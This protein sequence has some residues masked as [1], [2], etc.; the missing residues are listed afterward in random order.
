MPQVGVTRTLPNA[1]GT[2]QAPVASPQTPGL[3][4]GPQNKITPPPAV[5]PP[6]YTPPQ[7]YTPPPTT[8][9]TN[10]YINP[11]TGSYY[12]PQ[13]YA[14]VVMQK[15]PVSKGSGDV[16]QYAGDALTNPNQT[17]EQLNRS[18]Y[19][20]NNARND[21]AVGQTDPYDITQGGKIVYSPQERAAIEKAYAGIY[22]PALSDVF[23]KLDTK[24]K[25]E[26]SDLEQKNKLELMAKQHE[27]NLAEQ[28]DKAAL[29]GAGGI[30]GYDGEFAGTIDLVANMESSVFGKKN[31]KQQLANLLANKDYTTA[32]SQIAN[33]V[34]NGLV[35]ESKQKFV[36][37][38]TDYNVMEGMKEA[39]KAYAQ[40]G[41][42]MGLLKG[43]EEEI[44]RKLGIDSGKAS[45][46]AVQLW[47]EFQV[48][49]NNMTGAAF[50]AAES[51]D[52]ASVNPSLG[53]S[54]NLNLAVIEGA[55]NQ[56]KNRITSTI[57]ERV[58]SAQKILKLAEGDTSSD[59]GADTPSGDPE[60]DAYLKAIK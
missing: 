44:K 28:R 49:R 17:K 11:A 39:I 1:G 55:Q 9:T 30:T 47:R 46:L 58:P 16:T 52:Y 29:D 34:E 12:T 48:Y 21:I 37:A 22:D 20:L 35:G 2:Y 50:G 15:L 19:S 27:Y 10:K 23:T 4:I 31:V 24:A 14:N 54:L 25:Q 6:I 42:D 60:Y 8:Q 32:Y 36:N 26:A 38:R 40:G 57:N 18:A 41:G 13:E 53:K 5:N 7:S 43:T 51:R 45:T 59:N 56:L 3:F 33:S